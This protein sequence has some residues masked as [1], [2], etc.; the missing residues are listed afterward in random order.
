MTHSFE[1][2]KN[3]LYKMANN[4]STKKFF[5]ECRRIFY[6]Y[7]YVSALKFYGIKYETRMNDLPPCFL[8]Q[9]QEIQ[10]ILFAESINIGKLL[11]SCM[12]LEA[13]I[14]KQCILN[15]ISNN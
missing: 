1:K 14:K 2:M 12:N 8:M 11:D 7:G 5:F 15:I 13:N 10:K 4:N 3:D 9:I 6:F